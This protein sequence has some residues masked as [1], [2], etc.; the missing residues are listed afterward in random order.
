MKTEEEREFEFQLTPHIFTLCQ[1]RVYLSI[2]SLLYTL[3]WRVL[4]ELKRK[5]LNKK[6]KKVEEDIATIL[7]AVCKNDCKTS[8]DGFVREYAVTICNE[9]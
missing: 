6:L 2:R 9:K 4:I 5:N 8:V 1:E 7:V 3:N